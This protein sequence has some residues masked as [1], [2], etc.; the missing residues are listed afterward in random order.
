MS[1]LQKQENKI[2]ITDVPIN[3]KICIKLVGYM[4]LITD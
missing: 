4:F 1:S 2:L 3:S